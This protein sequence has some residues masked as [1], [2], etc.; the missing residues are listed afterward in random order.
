[1]ITANEARQMAGPTALDYLKFID[2]EIR[3]AAQNKKR[4]VFI[5]SNPYASWLYS[6]DKLEEEPK[7]VIK[8]LKAYGYEVE[9][10]YRESQFV[11]MA[12]WIKW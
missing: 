10:Y 9:L 5:R 3:E 8:E 7:K 4:E 6:P 2:S 12:L 1:M 11:D